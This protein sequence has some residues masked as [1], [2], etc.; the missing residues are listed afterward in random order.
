MFHP[1]DGVLYDNAKSFF[2]QWQQ[3]MDGLTIAPTGFGKE[4][5]E[6]IEGEI[7]LEMEEFKKGLFVGDVEDALIATAYRLL[8]DCFRACRSKIRANVT[9]ETS[10]SPRI[11]RMR[12]LSARSP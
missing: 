6:H 9:G 3:Q 7:D 11:V 1:T 8:S 4:C 2:E 12:S 5:P 10:N